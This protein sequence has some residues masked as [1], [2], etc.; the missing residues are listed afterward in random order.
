MVTVVLAIA[1]SRYG[2][3]S[4]SIGLLFAA[5]V[6]IDIA[7]SINLV[8]SQR[9][10]LALRS[11]ASNRLNGLLRLIFF[12]SGALASALAGLAYTAGGWTSVCAIQLGF[13]AGGTWIYLTTAWPWSFVAR[14][15]AERRAAAELAQMSDHDRKDLGYPAEVA[16]KTWEPK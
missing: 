1:L 9:E 13:I 5:A 7:L 6:L 3:A 15:L 12:G 8:L 14:R 10:L 11:A 4:R 2:A 16:I